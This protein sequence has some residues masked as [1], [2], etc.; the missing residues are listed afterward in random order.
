MKWL[1]TVQLQDK[2]LWTI[3]HDVPTENK[4]QNCFIASEKINSLAN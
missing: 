2:K 1:Q 4:N 3:Y